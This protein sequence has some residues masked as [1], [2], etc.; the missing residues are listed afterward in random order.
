VPKYD[1][2]KLEKKVT[3]TRIFSASSP[4]F[5]LCKV[6]FTVNL[7]ACLLIFLNYLIY[8]S[9][10]TLSNMAILDEGHRELR[11]T[12]FLIASIIL[13]YIFSAPLFKQIFI[14]SHLTFKET[15]N[16]SNINR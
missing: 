13:V 9:L 7:L 4:Y 12:V 10:F 11:D 5:I 1:F 2:S 14:Y 6:P 8:I 3:F 15:A 16:F